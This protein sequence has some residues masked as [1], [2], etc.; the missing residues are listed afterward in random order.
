MAAEE[1]KRREREGEIDG[2]TKRWDGKLKQR[3]RLSKDG[4][5][6]PGS[7]YITAALTGH[8]SS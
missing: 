4:E 3:G 6:E 5:G 1:T 2:R 8:L 7:R